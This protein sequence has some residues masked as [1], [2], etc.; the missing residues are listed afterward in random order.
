ME[1]SDFLKK[2]FHE[3]YSPFSNQ[4]PGE[5][6][7]MKNTAL[8]EE[9][10]RT[11]AN[12]K[13]YVKEVLQLLSSEEY[14][15]IY[16][17]GPTGVG[18]T[19]FLKS[20]LYLLDKKVLTYY[21][22]CSQATNL[23]DIILS[24]F[25]YLKKVTVKDKE[26]IKTFRISETFSIDERL[27]NKIKNLEK[28]LLIF[29]DGM[30]NVFET[31]DEVIKNELLDFLN[32]ISSIST[33]KVI[34]AG[35]NLPALENRKK[36]Y[37][38]NLEGLNPKEAFE[39]IRQTGVSDSEEVIQDICAITSGYPE[40]IFLFANLVKDVNL[41]PSELIGR[42]Q[43]S[44]KNFENF[45][46]EYLYQSIP[47]E[48][49]ELVELFALVRHS[50][51]IETMKE[52]NFI[53]DAEKKIQQLNS[54]RILSE[55]N[56]SFQ[57]K[58][59][60]K[61]YIKSRI[62]EQ[63][64]IR[65][66]N[67][68]YEL[69]SEQIAVK[70]EQRK[71]PVSRKLLYSE[72][73]FHYKNLT[74]LGAVPEYQAK[75]FSKGNL[76]AII[77]ENKES[78]QPVVSE[79]TVSETEKEFNKNLD[80][81]AKI[82]LTEEEKA[83]IF[84]EMEMEISSQADNPDISENNFSENIEKDQDSKKLELYIIE[85]TEKELNE[86]LEN[87]RRKGDKFNYN[88]IL[89]KLANLY[90]EHFKHD[91]ALRNYYAVLNS[92]PEY[93]PGTIVPSV[94][95]NIGEIYDYRRDF[96]TSINYFT[97]ALKEVEK[98]GSIEQKAEIYFKTALSYDDAGDYENALKFYQK[99]IETSENPEKNPFL[100]AACSNTAAIYDETGYLPGAIEF[101]KKSIEIDARA[102]NREGE[103]EV[104]S[105]LGNIYF[106][107]ENYTEARKCFYK[108]LNIA[109]QL[110]DPYKIAMSYIDIGDILFFEKNYEKA[111]K[112][113]IL[114]KKS[115]DK[116]ISTDSKEKIDRRF[117]QVIDEIGQKSYTELLHKIKAKNE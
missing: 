46:T 40:S 53:D 38:V 57:I 10:T 58:Q 3:F 43:V 22:E 113:F 72:Q 65:L 7:G 69:Y 63:K 45:I 75:N 79:E 104:L 35:E 48:S 117:Q 21:Y 76:K 50:F 18:K 105:K 87:Y 109:K 111:V 17:N 84:N 86:T 78:L 64:R 98:Q 33:I 27:I 52:I 49:K 95:G 100:A 4:A 14:K 36:V 107:T 26:Y 80:E 71:F 30:E 13:H 62:P 44:G 8:L 31:A 23:D 51:S 39:L 110:N 28:P 81:T 115:I 94:L 73:Y 70:L 41:R 99:N 47:G 25:N 15:L 19:H 82:E 66:Y 89:F 96:H 116:T 85:A 90:K 68:L 77:P 102:K 56:G 34:A 88:F 97:R 6:S 106:E 11:I 2:G 20:L 54:L 61:G 12:R 67:W 24:L 103:Y 32:F 1:F 42:I 74:E 114:A 9:I 93:I 29:I 108:E 60:L 91:Q 16:I 59:P 37:T 101:Y 112:A 55:N 83:L 92:E 5:N